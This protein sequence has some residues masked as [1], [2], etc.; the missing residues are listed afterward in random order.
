MRDPRRSMWNEMGTS[1][2]ALNTSLH[3]SNG[4]GQGSWLLRTELE[5]HRTQ[6]SLLQKDELVRQEG[7]PGEAPLRLQP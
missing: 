5:S 6:R 2:H 1:G 3:K 7:R 4:K